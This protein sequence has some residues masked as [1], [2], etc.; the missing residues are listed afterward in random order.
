VRLFMGFSIS[1][2]LIAILRRT[3]K[4]KDFPYA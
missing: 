4:L 3:P 1:L 2:C